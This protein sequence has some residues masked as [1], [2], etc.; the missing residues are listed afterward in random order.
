[1]IRVE[2][3]VAKGK[4]L[5]SDFLLLPQCFQ[6]SSAANAPTVISCKDFESF[7]S[8]GKKKLSTEVIPIVYWVY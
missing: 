6:M 4:L 1:M 7:L 3:I 5:M 8:L 2:N